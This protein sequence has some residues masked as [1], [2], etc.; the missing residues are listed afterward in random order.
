[1]TNETE[2]TFGNNAWVDASNIMG[3][4]LYKKKKTVYNGCIYIVGII[5]GKMQV[6]RCENPITI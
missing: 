6:F 3:K 5:H 1:M 2:K 4:R